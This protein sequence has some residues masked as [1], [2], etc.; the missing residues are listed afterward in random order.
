MRTLI[1]VLAIL[2][3]VACIRVIV[4]VGGRD[5]DHKQVIEVEP[6]IGVNQEKGNQGDRP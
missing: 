2:A 4:N 5:V 3:L 1:A 6:S